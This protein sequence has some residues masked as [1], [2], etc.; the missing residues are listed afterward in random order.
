MWSCL[1]VVWEVTLQGEVTVRPSLLR[2]RYSHG[3]VRWQETVLVF[4]GRKG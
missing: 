1:D 2:G 4:G 3:V